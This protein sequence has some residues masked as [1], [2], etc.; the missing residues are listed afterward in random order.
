MS[1]KYLQ[2]RLGNSEKGRKS[3]GRTRE[4]KEHFSH[5][6]PGTAGLFLLLIKHPPSFFHLISYWLASICIRPAGYRPVSTLPGHSECKEEKHTFPLLPGSG[7]I[8]TVNVK[9][10]S[11]VQNQGL[12]PAQGL[13]AHSVF[14]KHRPVR[15]LFMNDVFGARLRTGIISPQKAFQLRWRQTQGSAPRAIWSIQ[16]T[17]SIKHIKN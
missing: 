15:L 8:W 11:P 7:N 5:V 16:I 6:F 2:G 12:W 1:H 9:W 17:N 10:E 3:R 13:G 14:H 4:K